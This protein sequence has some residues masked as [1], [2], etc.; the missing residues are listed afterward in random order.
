MFCAI[1]IIVISTLTYS[2]C[3]QAVSNGDLVISKV[4]ITGGVGKTNQDYI[5]IYNKSNAVIDLNGLRLVKRTKTGTS[6]TSIKSWVNP[7]LLNPGDYHLWANNSDGFA[8]SLNAQSDSSQTIADDN[9]V[10]IREGAENTGTIIDSFAWGSAANIFVEGAPYT[11]NHSGGQFYERINNQDTNNN[12]LDWQIKDY[13]APVVCGNSLLESGETCDDGNAVSGDGCSNMCQTETN[14]TAA[15]DIVIN[16]IVS[17]ASEEWIELYSNKNQAS[18]IDGWTIE[19]GSDS[20]TLLSGTIDRWQVISKPKG[21]LNNSGD[22]IILKNKDGDTIDS[23]TYGDWDDGDLSDN[24]PAADNPYSLAR[25]KDG[26]TT[27]NNKNDFSITNTITKAGANIITSTVENNSS[28]TVVENNYDY[29]KDIII[30]EI[31]PNPKGIDSEALN[32]EFIEL[33]NK[34]QAMVNLNAWRIEVGESVMTINANISAGEYLSL[35]TKNILPLANDG[36]TVKLFQALKQTSYQSVTYK[37]ALEGQSYAYFDLGAWQWTAQA[38]PAKAN[39]LAALPSAS[40]EILDDPVVSQTVRFDSSDSLISPKNSFYQWSFGDGGSSSL[41]NPTHSFL[42]AGKTKVSL[43]IKNDYG[44]STISKTINVLKNETEAIEINDEQTTNV[45]VVITDLMANP[46]GADSDKEWLKLKN[47]S[48]VAVD[49][50]GY[51][52]VDSNNK[53]I[54]AFKDSFIIKTGE[55]KIVDNKILTGS[56]GNTKQTISLLDP[57]NKIVSTLTYDKSEEGKSYL[58]SQSTEN[59]LSIASLAKNNSEF[60]TAGTAICSPGL[61]GSQYFY[62]LP[63]HGEPLYEIYNSK[64]LFPKIKA[65]DQLIITGE[66]SETETGP[67]LKTKDINNIQLIGTNEIIV[68]ELS[69]SADLK[70]AP[71]PRLALVQ[72]EIVSKKYPRIYL[73]DETGEIELY[74]STNTKLKSSNFNI[75]DKISV[76]GVLNLSGG[77]PRLQ[78]RSEDDIKKVE[79]TDFSATSASSP[80]DT[81]ASNLDSSKTSSKQVIFYYLIAGGVIAL[82]GLIYFLYKK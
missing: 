36:A 60:T 65:G 4:Q 28:E 41:S 49:L 54:G 55:E 33:F 56:L 51:K 72:G 59:S 6:D 44:S 18:S 80:S 43:T 31:F 71:Y 57:S 16:E 61:F 63:E 40:F 11:T 68:P 23:V 47:N 82:G 46:L 73:A 14:T 52:I 35:S 48:D 21:A 5:S 12:L 20:K 70:Q 3:A 58:E 22:I 2:Y 17:D 42:K 79:Q 64:K 77:T 26:E 74:L 8:V 29:S 50:K 10:A 32:G 45:N 24:A 78:P 34:G 25:N 30:S 62:F 81:I 76:F 39:F 15:D 1:F 53:T 67:R 38:T 7:T 19:D 75:G 13:I 69:T 27:H 37:K 66:Y 9:G